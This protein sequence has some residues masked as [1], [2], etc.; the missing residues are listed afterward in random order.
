M[1]KVVI[2][3]NKVSEVDT[4]A[5]TMLKSAGF[6]VEEYPDA[7]LYTKEKLKDILK[8]ADAV[9]AGLEPYTKEVIQDMP[10]LKIIA[11]RGVGI[12]AIDQEAIRERGIAL[13][14]TEGCVEDAVS[15]LV[16]A[17][18]LEHA[19]NISMHNREMKQGIWAYHIGTG[20]KGK[21]LGIIGFGGIGKATASR[22]NAFGMRVV[23]YH[24][25][26][27]PVAEKQYQAEY[28]DI[29]S[30]LAQSDYIS[31]SV[32]LNPETKY[33]INKSTFERMKA[34]AILINT[35]R[36]GVVNTADLVHAI[37]SGQ[38][39]GACID[40]FEQEPCTDSPLMEFD[41]VI[42]T[43]HIGTFTTETFTAM[44]NHCANSIINFF[45]DK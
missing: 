44:N 37:K 41:N 39:A 16:M 20:L 18:I 17:Y 9:I 2:T 32:P 28:V 26:S 30:L 13:T 45:K 42:L 34:S 35:A 15:D 11:R 19:R 25:H 1:L 3:A 7:A 27:D 36:G 33:L 43:P 12:D 21:T 24:R 29:D 10:K 38:I 22:A 40:V 5:I 23:C 14:R 4:E 6:L 8:D 31:V